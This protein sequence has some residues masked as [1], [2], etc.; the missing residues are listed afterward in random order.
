MSRPLLM[1]ALRAELEGYYN[2]RR[3]K[4]IHGQWDTLERAHVLSQR[5]FVQ[6][7]GVHALMLGLAIR[8]SD[9]SEVMGQLARLAL[10]PLGHLTGRIPVGNTGRS[11]VSA[12]CPMPVP[13]DL[14][15]LVR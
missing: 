15:G 4:D 6:H 11:N 5:L 13:D 8:S 12:F 7:L 10:V 14:A 1:A 3:A 9:R 2:A